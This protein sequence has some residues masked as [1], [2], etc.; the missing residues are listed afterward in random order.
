MRIVV[1]RE[2]AHRETRVAM[3]PAVAASLMRHSHQVVVQAGAG[4][5]AA[6]SDA[7]Y[8][9]A[10]ATIVANTADLYGQAD[11]VLKV[12]PPQPCPGGGLHEAALMPRGSTFIGFLRPHS[13]PDLLAVLCANHITGLAMEY[14]PRLARAQSMDALTSMATVAGYKAVVLAANVTGKLFP[15]M[16]TAAGTVQPVTVLVLGAGVAGLQAIATA[17]RLGARVQAFDPRPSVREQVQSL[18]ASF[19]EMDLPEDAETAQGY[20]REMTPEFIAREQAVIGAR[21][22]V[23]DVVIST[24]QVFGRPAPILITADMVRQMQ[25]GSVIVDLA[26]EQGGN[27]ALTVPGQQVE[28][29]GVHILGAVNLPASMPAAAS[30]LYARNASNLLLHVLGGPDCRL[31]LGDEITRQVLITFRGEIVH[32]AL[33]PDAPQG[34]PPS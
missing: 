20:A 17:R 27:C 22:S 32:P 15:L 12:Q 9:L 24:A 21:L 25:P 11:V 10:G 3:V 23:V 1:P 26:A 4:L 18:G 28:R 2:T 8:Q 33:R 31:D 30:Q 13:S 5:A 6:F 19:L 16:M 34:V 14:V 7:D 29:H